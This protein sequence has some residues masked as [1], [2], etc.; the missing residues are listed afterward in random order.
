MFYQCFFINWNFF[1]YRNKALK[2]KLLFRQVFHNLI[3]EIGGTSYEFPDPL[4]DLFCANSKYIKIQRGSAERLSKSFKL[5]LNDHISNPDSN[6]DSLIYLYIALLIFTTFK[7]YN[8]SSP[9]KY[10]SMSSL[11]NIDEV[12]DISLELLNELNISKIDLQL[13]NYLKEM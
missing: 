7:D 13:E 2:E 3:Q 11:T 12:K 10:Q 6:P 8:A 9:G 5:R 1:S 4:I